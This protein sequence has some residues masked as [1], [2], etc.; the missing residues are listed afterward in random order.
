MSE[1]GQQICPGVQSQGSN[2]G[3]VHGNRG[4]TG[5][6][7]VKSKVQPLVLSRAYFTVP[8]TTTTTA[9]AAGM[10]NVISARLAKPTA[11]NL[12]AQDKSKLNVPACSLLE[13]T[14]PA[15]T[16]TASTRF[17]PS[18]MILDLRTFA[19]NSSSAAGLALKH[20]SAQNTNTSNV[21]ERKKTS[22][23]SVS[24]STFSSGQPQ[25][26]SL[27]N[28]S[29][30]QGGIRRPSTTPFG[31]VSVSAEGSKVSSRWISGVLVKD[32]G[33]QTTEQFNASEY[34]SID[35]NFINS[36]SHTPSLNSES[37][38]DEE[39][40]G[41]IEAEL[42]LLR[43]GKLAVGV[44]GVNS[45]S[46]I[47]NHKPLYTTPVA[48]DTGALNILV[49]I[50]T[51]ASSFSPVL[52]SPT[53]PLRC[54]A[55]DADQ[56]FSRK[57]FI[58]NEYENDGDKREQAEYYFKEALNKSPS[59]LINK[60]VPPAWFM[61]TPPS[62]IIRPKAHRAGR[63]SKST[64]GSESS[65]TAFTDASFSSDPGKSKQ[66]QRMI[67]SKK[68][69]GSPSCS[70]ASGAS[71]T[72]TVEYAYS[73]ASLLYKGKQPVAA[74]HPSTPIS[75]HYSSTWSEDDSSSSVTS[76]GLQTLTSSIGSPD[77]SK[78]T[79]LCFEGRSKG[80]FSRIGGFCGSGGIVDDGKSGIR[81]GGIVIGS[82]TAASGRC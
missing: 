60:H 4:T 75:E 16:T 34:Q 27:F 59:T 70:I 14:T 74:Y 39:C 78:V 22:T 36:A 50:S 23:P 17:R 10:A 64:S 37:G 65:L 69:T 33:C 7:A 6:N 15:A 79:D 82:G 58:S 45:S 67:S 12:Q 9:A 52:E 13:T 57:F 77:S 38:E 61:S 81:V 51:T 29:Q 56:L 24:I 31:R 49:P 73:R 19:Q 26:S 66:Q 63:S 11:V 1:Q 43:L 48:I 72:A 68:Q 32:A 71:S 62:H 3:T 42:R 35:W 55:P 20:S 44:V 25:K 46:N 76:C 28:A 41:S 18:Q 5:K 40:D 21:S 2:L 80:A 53:P 8:E 30:I 54:K 47:K